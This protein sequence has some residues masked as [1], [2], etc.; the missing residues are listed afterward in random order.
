MRTQRD[1]DTS[2]TAA[3][4][5]RTGKRKSKPSMPERAPVAG[6][7][8]SEVSAE[9]SGSGAFKAEA[10]DIEAAATH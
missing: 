6:K 9:F 7:P 3:S 4:E 1:Q 5:A 2:Q 8:L 10:A